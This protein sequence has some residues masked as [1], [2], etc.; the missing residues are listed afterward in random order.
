MKK[1]T[2]KQWVLVVGSLLVAFV[3]QYV[4]WLLIMGHP[5]EIDAM[6]HVL[7]TVCLAGAFVLFG[8]KFLKT[9]LYK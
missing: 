5:G 4:L 2:A 7:T 3:I 8:D 6:Y 1:W 9:N